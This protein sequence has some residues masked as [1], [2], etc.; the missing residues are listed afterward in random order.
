MVHDTLVCLNMISSENRFA[1]FR[2]M[3]QILVAE[4]RIEDEGPFIATRRGR[5]GI[6]ALGRIEHAGLRRPL[7]IG[8]ARCRTRRSVRGRRQVKRS[9]AA[10]AAERQR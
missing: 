2:I 8:V 1:L 5:R 10:A 6:R 7:A 3:L 9:L 4:Q